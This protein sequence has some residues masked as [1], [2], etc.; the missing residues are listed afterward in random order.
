[1]FIFSVLRFRL[2]SFIVYM[3]IPPQTIW[4][5]NKNVF[6][7]FFSKRFFYALHRKTTSALASCC[8]LLPFFLLFYFLLFVFICSWCCCSSKTNEIHSYF[9]KVI[10]FSSLLLTLIFC[11][12][13]CEFSFCNNCLSFIYSLFVRFPSLP[14][15]TSSTQF[16][17]WFWNW[18][19]I[20]S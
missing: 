10:D 18:V 8:L 5:L 9:T 6:L 17:F 11:L 2:F 14:Y 12:C 7:F 1:M 16:F 3:K 19:S 15:H 4:S 20:L 13:I